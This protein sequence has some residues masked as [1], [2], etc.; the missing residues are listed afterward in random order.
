VSRTEQPIRSTLSGHMYI[1]YINFKSQ[2]IINKPPDISSPHLKFGCCYFI[3][4]RGSDWIF[5]TIVDIII[6]AGCNGPDGKSN[7]QEQEY[8]SW[9]VRP[10]LLASGFFCEQNKLN[11]LPQWP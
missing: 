6:I 11:A 5:Y 2:I 7:S 9:V 8:T 1:Y 3:L 4:F 10:S